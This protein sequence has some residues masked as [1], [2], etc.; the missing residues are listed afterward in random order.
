MNIGNMIFFFLI[1]K[2]PFVFRF[3]DMGSQ[4]LVQYSCDECSGTIPVDW[5]SAVGG[6]ITAYCNQC[7][8]PYVVT[9]V[10]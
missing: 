5:E 2:I 7:A 10:P 9:G 6:T 3:K 1:G 8:Q 4:Y